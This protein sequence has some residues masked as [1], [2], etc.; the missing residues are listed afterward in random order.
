MSGRKPFGAGP[1]RTL[2]WLLL[3]L[4]L[5]LATRKWIGMPALVFGTSMAPALQPGQIVLVHK[6]AYLWHEP[7]RGDI[8]CIWTGSDLLL[9]RIIGLPGEEVALRKGKLYVGGRRVQEPYVVHR[10]PLEV[11]PG[12]IPA[13]SF[14]IIGDNRPGTILAVVNRERIVG[15]LLWVNSPRFRVSP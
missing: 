1:H 4:V 10:A 15:K 7:A 5:V 9:K 3:V 8:V 13:N 12:K 2:N 11:A 14:A 6:L